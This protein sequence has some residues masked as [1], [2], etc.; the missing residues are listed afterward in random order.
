[1]CSFQRLVT[2]SHFSEV[3]MMRWEDA[4]VFKLRRESDIDERS[5]E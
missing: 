4:T 3:V 1:M 5:E 2:A